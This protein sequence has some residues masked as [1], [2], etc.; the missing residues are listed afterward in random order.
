MS[1]LF[2]AGLYRLR[3]SKVFWLALIF[4]AV[5]S[6]ILCVEMAR[7]AVTD[8]NITFAD[9]MFSNQAVM[10]LVMAVFVTLFL[11][12][13]YSDRTI[14]NK[15]ISGHSRSTIYLAAFL[16][17][18]VGG[19]IIYAVSLGISAGLG[20]LLLHAAETPSVG[21]IFSQA[22]IGALVCLVDAAFFTFFVMVLGN[23]TA[24][25]VTG[26]VAGITL[27]TLGV[28][29][30]SRLSEDEFIYEPK[31]VYKAM[32]NLVG[33]NTEE[34]VDFYLNDDTEWVKLPNPRYLSGKLRLV[35]ENLLDLNPVGQRA[36]LSGWEF[37]KPA[38]AVVFDLL[39]I[40]LFGAAG[41]LIFRKKVLK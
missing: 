25:A 12:T 1:N 31:S 29:V 10:N 35:Y 15:I 24:G 8:P 2:S 7:N 4:M 17:S 32:Q 39:E 34:S 3:K 14:R 40:V 37:A 30:Y 9:G 21:K 36:E 33:E 5:I 20:S 13:E 6:V 23:K 41:I 18:S 26:L 38:R 11:G 22:L 28:A 16:V 27:L 19:L